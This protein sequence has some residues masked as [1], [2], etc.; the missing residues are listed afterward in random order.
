MFSWRNVVVWDWSASALQWTRWTVAVDAETWKSRRKRK[1]MVRTARAGATVEVPAGT[2][3]LTS[4]PQ[5]LVILSSLF[6][7]VT[8]E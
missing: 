5:S 8:V 6:Q 7:P 1:K 2:T 4:K 3:G